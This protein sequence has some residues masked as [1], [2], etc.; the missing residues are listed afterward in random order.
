MRTGEV[1]LCLVSDGSDPPAPR[2]CK[3]AFHTH[4]DAKCYSCVTTPPCLNRIKLS[5][6]GQ[7]RQLFCFVGINQYNQDKH[8]E[9]H[10]YLRLQPMG[11]SS[12]VSR[13]IKPRRLNNMQ[14][15]GRILS[16]VKKKK[17]KDSWRRR[18]HGN[19]KNVIFTASREAC[20]TSTVSV[21]L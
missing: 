18:P 1:I 15:R 3:G 20:A 21:H 13:K 16:L 7:M 8:R 10:L 17:K 6:G 14:K 4:L 2:F 11:F 12:P 19:E 5:A 9:G